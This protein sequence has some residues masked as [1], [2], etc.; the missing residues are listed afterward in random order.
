MAVEGGQGAGAQRHCHFLVQWM[1]PT[2]TCSAQVR[3]VLPRVGI[4]RPL[5]H[6]GRQDKPIEPSKG[7]QGAWYRHK[8]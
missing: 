5:Q 7:Q 8:A 1:G 6:M 4:R 3:A 2:H